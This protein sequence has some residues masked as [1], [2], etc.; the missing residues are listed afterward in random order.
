MVT[1]EP[2]TAEAWAA[3]RLTTIKAYAEDMVRTGSWRED[4]ADS[5]AVEEF[6]RNAPEGQATPGHG[7]YA[8]LDEAGTVVGSAWVAPA[9]EVGRGALFFYNLV[10][11]PGFRGRGYGRASMAAVERLALSLG[12]DA[13]WLH[14]FGDNTIARKLY[15]SIGYVETDVSMLKSLV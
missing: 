2:M 4:G 15:L 9:E 8:V 14:V 1:L 3:W 12:Y 11:E 13:L 10:I 6:D 5:K 7:F